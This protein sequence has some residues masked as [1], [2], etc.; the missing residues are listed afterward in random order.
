MNYIVDFI[1]TMTLEEIQ[2]YAVS[3]NITIVKHL[4]TFK[5]VF[6]VSADTE[7]GVD[8]Q[9]LVVINDDDSAIQLLGLDVTLSDSDI[10]TSFEIA[11]DKNWWK[12]AS[13]NA[14]DFDSST[15]NH[16]VRGFGS[17]VYLMDSGIEEAHPEFVDSE[18]VKLHSFTEDFT[19]T[20]GHGTALAS[21]ISGKTCGLTGATLKIVK[22]FDRSTPLKQSDLLFAFNAI[23]ED[24]IASGKPLSIVNMSWGF[25]KNEYINAKIEQLASIGL[26]LV[27]AAGNAGVAI[28]D[29][30]P[31]SIPSVFTVG[32]YDETL[33]PCDFSNYTGDDSLVSLTPAPTNHGKLDTWAP[34]SKIWAAGLNNTYGYTSGTSEAAAIATGALAYNLSVNTDF[35]GQAPEQYTSYSKML[36]TMRKN[37]KP[38]KNG[39]KDP[40][41]NLEHVSPYI[42]SSLKSNLLDLS[43]PK[44]A[45]SYNRIVTYKSGVESSQPTRNI[46]AT[47]NSIKY[48]IIAERSS[49][50]RIVVKEDLPDFVTINSNG[51]LTIAAPSIS[52]PYSPLPTIELDMYNR[53]G[54]TSTT[55]L[56][57]II[58]REDM[59]K[60]N[61][62]TIL[63][64]DDAVLNLMLYTYCS[65]VLASTGCYGVGSCFSGASCSFYYGNK[66]CFCFVG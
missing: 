57:I 52:D 8:E 2:Q 65:S 62:S 45:S 35:S 33:K 38:A 32:A 41:L 21:L 29:I 25:A 63:P 26:F 14:I 23:A 1:D 12:V 9:L 18:I 24:Y 59:T 55:F 3:K 36:E 22:I 49:V 47:A 34:G 28:D 54:S 46:F 16:V 66:Y 48:S 42:M 39:Y 17:T 43:D 61:A 31:A 20:T 11:E 7:L 4:P 6:I 19:D 64:V 60:E 5:N 37:W 10:E 27:A 44:Y 15:Y 50:A 40:S 56:N 30:T 13:I 53:D 51:L 58:L